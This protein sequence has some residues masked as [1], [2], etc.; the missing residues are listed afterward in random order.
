MFYVYLK[1]MSVLLLARMF[2]KCQLGQLFDSVVKVQSNLFLL[3]FCLLF[4]KLRDIEIS[5]V[6][7]DLSISPCHFV[8]FCHVY[9]E[10]LLLGDKCLGL[11]IP[12]D[13]FILLLLNA[14]LY[15]C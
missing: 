12:L 3:I 1:R 15:P 4:Y 2:Y 6:I 9:F 10:A 5:D 14:P 8:S 13:L 7:V 11:L